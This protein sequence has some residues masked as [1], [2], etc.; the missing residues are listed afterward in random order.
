MLQALQILSLGATLL[1]GLQQKRSADSAAAAAKEVGEFNAQMI[2][3]NAI[4][5]D[6]Q[7]DIINTNHSIFKTRRKIALDQVQ[8]T[9]RANTGYGGIDIASETTFQV[10]SRNAREHDFEKA[11]ADFNNAVVNMQLEDAKEDIRLQAVLSRKQGGMQA[12]NLR[13]QGTTALIKSIGTGVRQADDYG[14]FS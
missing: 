5:I 2:E 10:L 8:G 7:K 3:R 1:G 6:K 9:V 12:A 4:L 13:N 14:F 11:T